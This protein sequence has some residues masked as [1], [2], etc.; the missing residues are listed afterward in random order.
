MF[1][2]SVCEIDAI[3]INI[4]LAVWRSRQRS[5]HFITLK[6]FQMFSEVPEHQHLGLLP[7]PGGGRHG[8]PASALTGLS[9]QREEE[10]WRG[11]HEAS[12]HQYPQRQRGQLRGQPPLLPHRDHQCP[13]LLPHQPKLPPHL[14][15]VL[16]LPTRHPAHPHHRPGRAG[17]DQAGSQPADSQRCGLPH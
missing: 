7:V 3:C 15:P 2:G 4:L 11:R 12:H 14:Q 5:C 13:Q 16:P 8:A 1:R 9:A 17:G 10:Q 6:Y